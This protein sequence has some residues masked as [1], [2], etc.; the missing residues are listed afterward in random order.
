MR[1]LLALALF[2]PA[3][4]MA[5]PL[6][7]RSL[8]MQGDAMQTPAGDNT[9]R[10]GE[11]VRLK[12]YKPLKMDNLPL[13][14]M[15]FGPIEAEIGGTGDGKDHHFARYQ[16]EGTHIL[17]GHIGGSIDGGEAKLELTWPSH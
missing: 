17:G 2:V 11:Q 6:D 1:A 3:A 8:R 14:T 9:A 13:K 12:P 5:G 7:L 16:L 15:N 4:A 10:D